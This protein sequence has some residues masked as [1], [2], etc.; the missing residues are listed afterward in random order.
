[1]DRYFR[2][3]ARIERPHTKRGEA[4]IARVRLLFQPFQRS[5]SP[6][7][8]PLH[9]RL[10]NPGAAL[11]IAALATDVAYTNTLLF[12]WANFSIWLLTGG[13]LLAALAGLAL[14]LDIA[15]RRIT[16]IDWLRF[17]GFVAAALLSLLNAMVHSRDA[18]TAVAPDG[19]E[20][21]VLVSAILVILGRRG[22]SVA[23]RRSSR[24]TLSER[25]LS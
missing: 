20:L 9:P 3:D 16:G 4:S 6:P 19:L 14:I 10:I 1:M 22:W 18:Y 25:T 13:L 24:P 21:S 7:G 17:S 15:S 23:A 5:I 12:Q 2:T 8:Q 11:L